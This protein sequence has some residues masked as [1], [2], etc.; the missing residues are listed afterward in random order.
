MLLGSV[1]I[2]E[3]INLSFTA[4]IGVKILISVY[5]TDVL[6]FNKACKNKNHAPEAAGASVTGADS[7]W[8]RQYLQHL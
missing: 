1:G 2:G 7:Q 4:R 6:G 8:D 3:Y 5:Y